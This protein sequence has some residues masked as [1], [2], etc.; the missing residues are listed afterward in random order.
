[1][2]AVLSATQDEEQGDCGDYMGQRRRVNICSSALASVARLSRNIR[3]ANRKSLRRTLLHR[4]IR[5]RQPWDM[6]SN[7]ELG[8]LLSRFSH[9][10]HRNFIWFLI[11]SYVMA[12]VAPQAG[13]AI[14]DVSLG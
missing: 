6:R 5:V 12:A 10:L 1:M 9:F 2:L 4:M 14:K 8:H 11:G 13:L 7:M 3:Q